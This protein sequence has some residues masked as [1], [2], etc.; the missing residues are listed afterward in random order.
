M[1]LIHE[2]VGPVPRSP[3]CSCPTWA[4]ATP[5]A[6]R[7]GPWLPRREARL[8]GALSAAVAEGAPAQG[9]YSPWA[10]PSL[11][12]AALRNV[13]PLLEPYLGVGH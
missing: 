6:L 10:L 4:V 7:L 2:W 1:G 3:S 5:V 9:L 12:R 8:L 13:S 11:P